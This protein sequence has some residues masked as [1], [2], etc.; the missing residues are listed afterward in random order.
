M[1]A[2][3]SVS[4]N[5]ETA[6]AVSGL[7]HY[8]NRPAFSR[9]Y[10]RAF[11]MH[12]RGVRWHVSDDHGPP[13]SGARLFRGFPLCGAL[14]LPDDAWPLDHDGARPSHGAREFRDY[15]FLSP[16]PWLRHKS[17]LSIFD[18]TIATM[19]A[20]CT[21]RLPHRIG[22]VRPTSHMGHERPVSDVRLKFA[23]LGSGSVA[24][25]RQVTRR[26]NTRRNLCCINMHRA[27]G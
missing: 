7:T 16:G 17:T 12:V 24:K 6:S 4:R 1:Y 27:F 11:S 8:P 3:F 22:V 18:E 26:A 15:P 9:A 20:T 5:R 2:T 13:L 19:R 23:F 25:L 21:L 10:P 14:L